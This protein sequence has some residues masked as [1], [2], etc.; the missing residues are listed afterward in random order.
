MAKKRLPL[1]LSLTAIFMS[2]AVLAS[3]PFVLQKINFDASSK[4][5]K[6]TPTKTAA[7]VG[8]ELDAIF[9]P[10]KISETYIDLPKA[11]IAKLDSQNNSNYVPAKFRMVYNGKSTAQIN[12]GIRVKGTTT[13]STLNRLNYRP[14]FKVSFNWAKG[15]KTQTLFGKRS[16]TFNGFVQDSSRIHETYAYETYRAMGVPA[17]R[18]GFTTITFEG[19]NLPKQP[20]RGLYLVLES[21]DQ[22]FWAENF[23]DVTQ[24]VYENNAPIMDFDEQRIGGNVAANT[25]FKVKQGWKATPNRDD[26]R[27][28]TKA[29]NTT[30]K[31]FWNNLGN[32]ADREKLIMLFAVDNFTGNW[33]TYDGP[34]KN[35]F[36]FRSN[37]LGKFTFVPWGT[38][39]SFGENLFNDPNSGIHYTGFNFPVKVHDDFFITIDKPY[40]AYPGSFTFA[41]TAGIRDQSQM[42][43]YQISRGKLF[44][45]C[46]NYAP[47]ATLY[48]Q[49][50]KK[51]SDWTMKANLPA[52]MV[53]TNS[54]IAPLLTAYQK[55]EGVR[56][57][58]WVIK[59]NT[60]VATAVT[61]D[62]K[63]DATGAITKCKAVRG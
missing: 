18:T 59:Q 54:L 16:L 34:M 49:D 60:R 45:K 38:D 30:G 37:Q 17:P 57:A 55:A 12:V 62:C 41:Y 36:T 48:F 20:A 6:P 58:N 44:A 21:E 32:V 22:E 19:A 43:N 56:T 42:E 46:L 40:T 27:A 23:Q 25:Y 24:H 33:D 14:S 61:K 35:N 50:L 10:S 26:L 47:C 15:Y 28:F 63:V 2:V 29:I 9:D 4:N 13:H 7:P 39:Q 52:R 53:A 1:V 31:T 8:N 11:S 3:L 51:V 5:P